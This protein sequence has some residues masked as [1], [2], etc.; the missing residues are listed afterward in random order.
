MLKNLSMRR[1]SSINLLR[2]Y[3]L[4]ARSAVLA[5][6]LGS[7]V[8]AQQSNTVT[9]SADYFQQ[10]NPVTVADMI[11][12]IPGITVALETGQSSRFQNDRGL[13]SNENILINGQLT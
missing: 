8:L 7:S 3:Q 4:V 2:L 1:F 10:W 12:R 9:Y 11:D 5:T 13:G 6:L